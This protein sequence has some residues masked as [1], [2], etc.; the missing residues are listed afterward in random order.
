MSRQTR[1]CT[2][3]LTCRPR[4]AS[5]LLTTPAPASPICATWSTRC[6]RASPSS[7]SSSTRRPTCRR[8]SGWRRSSCRPRSGP[9]PGI[10][11]RC[12]PPAGRAAG[13][14]PVQVRKGNSLAAAAAGLVAGALLAGAGFALWQV[15]G[16]DRPRVFTEQ[17]LGP[18]RK[19]AE[20]YAG[21][22]RRRLRQGAF[23][24]ARKTPSPRRRNTRGSWPLRGTAPASSKR[25]ARPRCCQPV[26]PKS[27]CRRIRT[28][29]RARRQSSAAHME[30][31]RVLVDLGPHRGRPGGNA[32][33]AGAARV[34]R[35]RRSGERAGGARRRRCPR[36]DRRRIGRDRRA[37]RRPNRNCGSRAT[38]TPRNCAPIHP[39]PRCS[40]S[41]I[42]LEM[43]RADVQNLQHHG[44]DAV[45]SLAALHALAAKAGA[46]PYLAARIALLDAY[47]QPR[48]TAAMAYASAGQALAELLKH[49]EKDPL[50]AGQQRA[51]AIGLAA[52]RRNRAAR[53]TDPVRVQLPRPGCETLCGVRGV[54]AAERDRLAAPGAVAGASQGVRIARTLD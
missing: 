39:M 1:C 26:S 25:R 52:G 23:R 4:T 54:E 2:R 18:I 9:S 12:R 50:D 47:I 45:Q 15:R 48:G 32:Q 49:S 11:T 6:W 33:G 8:H 10:D 46:D 3:R 13:A 42:E 19:V 20:R 5:A 14:E 43:A 28:T 38:V 24:G 29:L 40:P 37:T 16:A 7:T 34:D 53:R 41:L 36:G 17:R 44:R 31:G 35:G 51:S 27:C 30:L 21:R 22:N